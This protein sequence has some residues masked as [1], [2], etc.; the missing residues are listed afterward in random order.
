MP[1][2]LR[3][4][5]IDGLLEELSKKYEVPK[6]HYCIYEI[7]PVKK[8]EPFVFPSSKDYLQLKLCGYTDPL[9]P[10]RAGFRRDGQSH[11][12]CYITFLMRGRGISRKTI[13]HEFIHYVHYV[14][15]GY[16]YEEDREAEEKRTR[17]ETERLVKEL[18]S[19]KIV[20]RRPL[21]D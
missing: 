3:V 20:I 15:N 16:K 9:I 4:E 12:I 5:E 11:E 17:N 21:G 1:Y 18:S 6:P 8:L 7:R 13:V 10:M 19:G 14:K 2:G